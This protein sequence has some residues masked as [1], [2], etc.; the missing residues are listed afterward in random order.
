[1]LPRRVVKVNQ[2]MN[3]RA[4]NGAKQVGPQEER[5]IACDGALHRSEWYEEC[6]AAEQ[7]SRLKVP[8]EVRY[9][10]SLARLP[11]CMKART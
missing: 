3:R 7:P 1:M 11:G 10:G 9:P 6:N 5:A 4:T 2:H 8:Y